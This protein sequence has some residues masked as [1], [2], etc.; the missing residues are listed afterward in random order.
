MAKKKTRIILAS[1][2]PRRKE[3]L[4]GLGLTFEIIPAVGEEKQIDGTPEEIVK[5]LAFHKAREVFEHED[6]GEDLTVIGSDTIVVHNGKILGKPKDADDAR[7]MLSSLSGQTHQ[8]YTGV[9]ILSGKAG[10]YHEIIFAEKTDVEFYPLDEE[11]INW[12]IA[13]GE[14]MDKAGA[15]GIQGKGGR[16]V[17]RIN[18]DYNTV[19]GLPQSRIYQE[20]KGMN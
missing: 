16:F 20:L 15:Y 2:S 11:E 10:R 8:V 14:P 9:A 4:K 6:A 17:R 5:A 18:G 19:V 12:Y 3:L 13:T 1:A 7:T